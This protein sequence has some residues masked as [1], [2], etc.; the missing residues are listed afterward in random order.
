MSTS[1]YLCNILRI[2]FLHGYFSFLYVHVHFQGYF[3]FLINFTIVLHQ[4]IFEQINSHNHGQIN[5]DI[6]NIEGHSPVLVYFCLYKIPYTKFWLAFREKK[7]LAHIKVT[8]YS[9]KSHLHFEFHFNH[10]IWINVHLLI[11]LHHHLQK[12]H[13]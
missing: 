10:R 11:C 1:I 6:C 5:Y 3:L 7:R 13:G 12:S 9:V 2:L 4:N 8:I